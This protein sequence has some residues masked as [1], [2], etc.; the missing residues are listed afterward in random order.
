MKAN[1]ATIS[2][3]R[4]GPECRVGDFARLYRL[5][6]PPPGMV[7]KKGRPGRVWAVRPGLVM[8]SSEREALHGGI[9]CR[10]PFAWF[11]HH[12]SVGVSG[13]YAFCGSSLRFWIAVH[14]NNVKQHIEVYMTPR[15]NWQTSVANFGHE[16]NRAPTVRSI[17]LDC[18][19]LPSSPIR[20]HETRGN[21]GSSSRFRAP[22][23]ARLLGG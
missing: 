8:V 22:T 4:L 15:C 18:R 17:A 19:L 10:T 1:D 5:W 11:R 14:A 20:Q 6:R 16:F 7:G 2:V 12:R 3:T 13:R 21:L 9:G 23:E